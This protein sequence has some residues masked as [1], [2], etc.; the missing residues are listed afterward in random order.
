MY[1]LTVFSF[2]ITLGDTF[3]ISLPRRRI[4]EQVQHAWLQK[5]EFLV[6]QNIL[7]TVA[8]Q[9]VVWLGI[10]YCPLL[11]LLNGTFIFLTFYLK[12]Y[13][14]L[15]N[16]RPAK[17]LFRAS[18]S[19]F[20]FQFVLL[21]GLAMAAGS[22]TYGITRIRPSKTCGLFAN[23]SAAW[24]VVPKAVETRL[25][26][27]AQQ[28]LNYLTSD[29]FSCPFIILLSLI[30]TMCV[31]QARVNKQAI[32]ELKRQL[33]QR[34]KEKWGLVGELAK[35]LEEP[36]A[37]GSHLAGDRAE[38]VAAQVFALIVFSC[39]IGEGYTNKPRSSEL[40]CVFNHNQD[41]C[42]YGVGIG[43]LGFLACVFFLLVDFYF[44][45][46]S[47]VTDRKYLVLADLA[48]SGIWTF[49]WF[50]G[51]CFLT[52]QWAWTKPTDVLVGSDSARAA[53]VF[54]F[55]SVFSWLE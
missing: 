11:P 42:R 50:V 2:L 54:S 18:S 5:E 24:K 30:L 47:N 32:K 22:L 43:V 27:A 44:P 46:I 31:S 28:V 34:V 48:F 51:F 20:F 9:T 55:F 3:L 45:Q 26:R 4:A 16:C 17:R 29:A 14:V 7:G 8:A 13:T 33:M 36:M 49:L 53:I 6:P 37:S 40:F 52:N 10:F 19:T 1:K 39:I 25:P 21:L 35:L 38:P 41:A 15:Q 12:K 23:Y